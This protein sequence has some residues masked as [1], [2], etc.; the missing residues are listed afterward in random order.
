MVGNQKGDGLYLRTPMTTIRSYYT[1]G[2]AL[3]IGGLLLGTWFFGRDS[4]PVGQGD[5]VATTTPTTATTTGSTS[6]ST[7]PGKNTLPPEPTFVL[8]EGAVAVDGYAY[9]QRSS[10]FFRSLTGGQ[11]LRIPNAHTATF[12]RL[13]DFFTYPGEAVVRDCGAAPLYAF[14]G[15]E[16]QVYLYQVWRAP[17][18][19]TSRVEVI[20][21]VKK[22][23]FELIHPQVVGDPTSL[24]TVGYTVTTSTT[25]SV[26]TCSL[27]LTKSARE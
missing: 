4:S 11:P 27:S 5:S 18:F 2:G 10:V 15:D 13:T 1:L 7:A 8:P 3:L 20:V 21:G 26:S 23:E 24:F 25:T 17:K 9:I 12:E 14:Y 16:R 19:R 6:T 22:D